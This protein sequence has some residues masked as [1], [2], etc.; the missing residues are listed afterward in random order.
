MRFP[1]ALQ[2]GTFGGVRGMITALE[3]TGRLGCYYLGTDP[4]MPPLTDS[5]E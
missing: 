2:V 4:D 1:V 3:D 5:Y